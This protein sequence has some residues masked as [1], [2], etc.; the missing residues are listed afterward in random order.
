M[1]RMYVGKDY[2]RDTLQLFL[3]QYQGKVEAQQRHKGTAAYD[4]N[5]AKMVELLQ[6]YIDTGEF[7]GMRL[8]R[9]GAAAR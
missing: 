2:D 3:R 7:E 1:N 6:A 4:E 8:P 9:E 5:A